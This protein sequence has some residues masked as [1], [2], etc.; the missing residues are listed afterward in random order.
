MPT[1]GVISRQMAWFE[2]FNRMLKQILAKLIAKGEHNWD[3]L[4]ASVLFAYRTTPHSST[5]LTPL[6]LLYGRNPHLPTSLDL[7][8]P[9]TRYPVMESEYAKELAKEL[10]QVRALAQKNI[11]TKQSE[12]NKYYD[13]RSKI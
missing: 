11:Q 6:Y 2:H 12:Q 9:V 7:A 13:R 8:I 3:S 1:S 5:G 4:L 10:K